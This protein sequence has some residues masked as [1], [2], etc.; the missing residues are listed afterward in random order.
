MRLLY[1]LNISNLDHTFNLYVHVC[2]NGTCFIGINYAVES[3]IK[4]VFK[5][6][7]SSISE[8]ANGVTKFAENFINHMEIPKKFQIYTSI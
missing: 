2:I 7:I 3:K 8:K 1:N 5:L 6:V 4:I